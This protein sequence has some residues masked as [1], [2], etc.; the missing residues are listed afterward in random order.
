MSAPNEYPLCFEGYRRRVWV[1]DSVLE[2]WRSYR[3]IGARDPE[4]FG[5]LV[6]TTSM[7]R[8]ERWIDTVTTPMKGDSQSRYRFELKDPRHQGVVNQAFEQSGGSQIY[9]GSW[10]THPESVPTPS[11]TDKSDWRACLKRNKKRPLMFVIAGT[12]ET[13]MFVPWGRFF[14]SLTMCEDAD[15]R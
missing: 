3:Q 8:R 6:G 11:A 2:A 13:R 9:L 15:V 4:S 10:H 1:A 7:N 12:S 5:V 14:R